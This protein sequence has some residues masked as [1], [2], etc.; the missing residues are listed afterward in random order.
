MNLF[1]VNPAA[2]KGRTHDIVPEIEALMEK[3]SLPYR[4]E[5]TNAPG[6]ATEI[7]RDY[8]KSNKDLRIYAVGGDGTLNEVLQGVVGSE[9]C[10]GAVPTGTGNDFIKTFC[11]VKDPLKLLPFLIHS[12]PVPVDVCKMN[13]RYYL[14]IASVGFDADVVATTQY[15]K[16]LPL[17][18]GKIAYIGGILLALIR[19]RNIQATFYIDD[20][21]IEMKSLLLSAFANGRYYGGGMI[22]APDAIPDD[23]LLDVCLIRG[24]SRLRIFRFFPRFI[25]GVHT[26]MEDVTITRC[27]NL[28]ME[29][30]APVHINADGE[31]FESAKLDISLIHNGLRFIKPL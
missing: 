1:I 21:K 3:H 13:D 26:Q 11:M 22:P 29:S 4:I 14:N 18:K 2:G 19:K 20:E 8:I 12:E 24:M 25:R 28:R 9:A 17:M 15:L 31:L 27:R 30:P 6:H 10:L 5:T 23:G 16:H 7:A